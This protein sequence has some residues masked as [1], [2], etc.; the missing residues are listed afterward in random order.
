MQ[1]LKI[2]KISL[3]FLFLNYVN[4]I[5]WNFYNHPF[6]YVFFNKIKYYLLNKEFFDLDYFGISEKQALEYILRN[7]DRKIIKIY[8][9]GYSMLEGSVSMLNY[10]ERNRIKVS[11]LDDSDYLIDWSHQYFD[12]KDKLVDNT[13]FKKYYEIVIENNIINT[14]YKKI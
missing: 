8:S 14:I 10:N 5:F 2:Y 1:S 11:K 9:F 6:Q 4:I 13:K 3:L 7:D 12:K